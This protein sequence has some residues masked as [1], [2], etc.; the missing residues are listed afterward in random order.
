LP[1]LAR[2]RRA[3]GLSPFGRLASPI[4]LLG[5]GLTSMGLIRSALP[6][7]V[8]GS[9]E[10]LRQARKAARLL[11]RLDEAVTCGRC[12][13]RAGILDL[14]RAAHLVGAARC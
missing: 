6:L 12:V 11:I 2:F 5:T 3:G 14:A 7:Q 4:L 10:Q 13:F 8:V 9:E 1:G